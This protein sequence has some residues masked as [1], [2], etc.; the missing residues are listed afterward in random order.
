M[1]KFPRRQFL[2]LA[3]GAAA[4][5]AA[6]RIARAQAYPTRPVRLIAPYPAG[7]VVDLMARLIGQWLS[8]RLGQ[9]FV[10][11]NRSG[12]GGNLG[13]EVAVRAAPDGYTLVQI[14]SSNAWSVALYDNLSFN[15]LR[16]LAPVASV[17]HAYGVLVVHP[18]FPAQS[19]SELIAYAKANPGKI[20]MASGGIGSAPHVYGELF[21]QMAGVD[22]AHIPYR[23]STSAHVDLLSGQVQVMFDPLATSIGHI[24]AGKLRALAVT[25]PT[26]L[27][28][29][30]DVATVSEFVPGYE[31]MGW[32]GIAA[33][34]NTP[35][36]IVDKLNREINAGLANPRIK[37]RIA[38]LGG[39]VVASSPSEFG[40]FMAAYT[41]KWVKI[42]RAANIKA[43]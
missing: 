9:T 1:M 10:V 35:A 19:V 5:P 40:M 12:A 11:E 2:H 38:D 25:A 16:D 6:S 41:E 15:F 30:P 7:G 31:A 29:L 27:S 26:R 8:E 17:Y 36:E 24:R 21:K 39:I 33:P 13:T 42:I 37:D 23:G 18:S 14:S 28:V 32:Q 20:N 43:E 3:A 34:R 22:L 4:L